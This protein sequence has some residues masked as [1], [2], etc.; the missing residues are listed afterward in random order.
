[1]KLRNKLICILFILAMMTGMFPPVLSSAAEGGGAITNL[2]AFTE[3]TSEAAKIS[4]LYVSKTD[5]EN[6]SFGGGTRALV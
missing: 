5:R 2:P 1:M 6:R 3:F 4:G